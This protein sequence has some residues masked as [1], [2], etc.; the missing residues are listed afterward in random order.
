LPLI[1]DSLYDLSYTLATKRTRFNWRAAIVA[2]SIDSLRDALSEKQQ[3]TRSPAE[4]G[5]GLV[6]TGQGAQWARMGLEL[7]HFSVFKKSIEAADKYMSTLGSSWSA[8]G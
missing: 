6:F 1:K 7:V 8:L 4:T 2:D 5:L 3:A